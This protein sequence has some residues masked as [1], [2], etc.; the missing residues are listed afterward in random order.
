[1]N[2]VIEVGL[3][4]I[5]ERNSRRKEVAELEEELLRLAQEYEAELKTLEKTITAAPTEPP[6]SSQSC[7]ALPDMT[8]TNRDQI[9]PPPRRNVTKTVKDAR[10]G[11]RRDKD[12][13]TRSSLPTSQPLSPK[14][15]SWES[16]SPAA[17]LPKQQVLSDD[18]EEVALPLE[19]DSSQ[20]RIVPKSKRESLG[21][22]KSASGKRTALWNEELEQDD[23]IAVAVKGK[24]AEKGLISGA[25]MR[26]P[27]VPAP[28]QGNQPSADSEARSASK[29]KSRVVIKRRLQQV[30]EGS[31]RSRSGAAAK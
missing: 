12:G 14:A 19:T 30:V 31:K 25:R 23:E 15:N 10:K 22:A 16:S 8:R 17:H 5:A 20:P 7:H 9:D 11:D 1:M 24:P 21:E 29:P 4:I 26:G 18:D 27:A 6:T 3:Q 2:Q 28:L 13:G